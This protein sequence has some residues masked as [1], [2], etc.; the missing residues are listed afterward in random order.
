MESD[1]P[2]SPAVQPPHL[3]NGGSDRI[4]LTGHLRGVTNMESIRGVPGIELTLHKFSTIIIIGLL[5]YSQQQGHHEPQRILS[6]LCFQTSRGYGADSQHS[7][8]C[9]VSGSQ[10]CSACA[11][12][13]P[14]RWEA[15]LHIYTAPRA[16]SAPSQV[17]GE[18]ML[19][20]SLLPKPSI[21]S[22]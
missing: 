11:F 18:H 21:C 22:P 15:P 2:A 7:R 20:H 6:L 19:F 4:S 12:L 16:S 3:R 13:P 17:S 1:C 14:W 8:P 10:L 5:S 9:R